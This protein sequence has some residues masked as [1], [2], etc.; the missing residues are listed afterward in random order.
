MAKGS[1]GRVV[2]YYDRISV[3]IL[4][5]NAPLS[6]GDMVRFQRG[7]LS[8]MQQVDSL[9]IDHTAV[10]KAKKGAVVGMKVQQRVESGTMVFPG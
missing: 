1:L 8:M 5:L 3:A 10:D 2:H 6:L 7:D 9:Q 4:E